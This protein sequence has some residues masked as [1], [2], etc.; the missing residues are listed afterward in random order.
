M[1]QKSII[2]AIIIVVTIATGLFIRIKSTWFPTMVNLYLGDILY[3]F[4]MFYIVSFVV[5]Q[6]HI[7]TRALIAITVCLAIEFLQLYQADWIN[8]IRQTL[9]GR[10]VLGS[11]FLWSDLLAYAIGVISAYVFEKIM[12]SKD[13]IAH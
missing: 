5:P 10:L 2:Y 3:A 1:K 6:K 11:G 4:M 8:S 12:L 13:N 9:P 7:N